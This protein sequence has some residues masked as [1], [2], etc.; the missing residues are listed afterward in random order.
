L[1]KIIQDLKIE[2]E[3]IK[4]LQRETSLE[5]EI[6]RKISGAIYA[7]ITNRIQEMEER[8]P[9][10]EDSIENIDKTI[11]GNGKCKKVLKQNIQ[12]IQDT[13]RKQNLRIIGIH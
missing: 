12:E 11:K 4:N 7:S 2:V 6:L 13:M 8:I 5:I 10:A 1:S 3:T 9:G